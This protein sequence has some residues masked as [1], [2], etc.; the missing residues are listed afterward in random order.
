VHAIAPTDRP[1]DQRIELSHR[2]SSHAAAGPY[3]VRALYAGF[4]A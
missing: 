1:S 4:W 2:A 3:Q